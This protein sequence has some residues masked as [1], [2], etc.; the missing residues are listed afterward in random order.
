[1]V[2]DLV[3]PG[4]EDG[5]TLSTW[6]SKARPAMKIINVSG[7]SKQSMTRKLPWLFLQKPYLPVQLIDIVE[8]GMSDHR[9]EQT[10][11]RER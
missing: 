3:M 4:S 11:D 9:I 7:Y 10:P 2:T 1:M 6:A 5:V 8:G